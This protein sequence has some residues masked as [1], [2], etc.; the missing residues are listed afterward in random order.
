MVTNAAVQ[1]RKE[2]RYRYFKWGCQATVNA[3]MDEGKDER[4]WSLRNRV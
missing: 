4:F 3:D 1:W 2:V